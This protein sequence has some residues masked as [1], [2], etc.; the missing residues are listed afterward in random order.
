[1]AK[2]ICTVNDYEWNNE[3]VHMS[4]LRDILFLE[5][6]SWGKEIGDFV[7]KE[8]MLIKQSFNNIDCRKI[9]VNPKEKSWDKIILKF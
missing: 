2:I 8:Q 4:N 5:N 3:L 6:E 7:A 1:M 9:E